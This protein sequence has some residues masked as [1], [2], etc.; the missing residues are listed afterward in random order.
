M[1]RSASWAAGGL[2]L[3]ACVLPNPAY[4]DSGAAG[5]EVSSGSGSQSGSGTLSGT[6]GSGSAGTSG[7]SGVSVGSTDAATTSGAASTGVGTAGPSTSDASASTTVGTTGCGDNCPPGPPLEWAVAIGGSGHQEVDNVVLSPNGDIYVIGAYNGELVIDDPNFQ[8]VPASLGDDVFFA[9]FTSSG[10][11]G[12]LAVINAPGPQQAE[13]LVRDSLGNLFLAICSG[14]D[15]SLAGDMVLNKGGLDAIVIKTNAQGLVL[16]HHAFT[17]PGDQCGLDLAID[18]TDELALVGHYV[19]S[20]N[21]EYSG[22][23]QNGGPTVAGF[24]IRIGKN[25]AAKWSASLAGSG[26]VTPTG[27]AAT[28]DDHLAI[29][30]SFRNGG[31]GFGNATLTNKGAADVFVLK[32]KRDTG[33][34]A[35]LF[36]DGGAQPQRATNVAVDPTDNSIL[37]AGG[38]LGKVASVTTMSPD[39]DA[40]LKRMTPKGVNAWAIGAGADGLDTSDALATNAGGSALWGANISGSLVVGDAPVES[41]AGFFLAERGPGDV[42]LWAAGYAATAGV[43]LEDVAID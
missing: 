26:E 17:G 8:A 28:T 24:V 36:G 21:S 33:A 3:A 2:L 30:G 19:S 22:L 14:G 16:D 12:S 15:M 7:S 11:L 29:A 27:V 9:R 39:L 20:L 43:T 41:G 23:L 35:W 13:G 5:G 6:S 34:L 31:I 42:I 32:V 4:D 25:N 37:V 18:E 40:F 10:E 38:F 1:L